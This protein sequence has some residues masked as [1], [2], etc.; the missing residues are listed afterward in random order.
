M[1]RAGIGL[2][3]AAGAVLALGAAWA[4]AAGLGP[5][6]PTPPAGSLAAHLGLCGFAGLV[7]VLLVHALTRDS[8]SVEKRWLL[9]LGGAGLGVGEWQLGR[10]AG[11]H[12]GAVEVCC[13]ATIP[14]RCRPGWRACTTMT[15]TT[16]ASCCE[17][18]RSGAQIRAQ[19][20]LRVRSADGWRWLDAQ[21]LVVERDH[22]ARPR[23]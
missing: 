3:S 4:A 21:L 16:C 8:L 7:T 20:E 6:A 5:L 19:R 14:P 13:A 1:V 22:P 11:P 9:A 15:A 23:A 18:L 2:A 17:Q 10:D 12:L